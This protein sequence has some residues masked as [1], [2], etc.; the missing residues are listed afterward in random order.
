MQGQ[1]HCCADCLQALEFFSSWPVATPFMEPN[2]SKRNYRTEKNLVEAYMI[3]VLRVVT[4]ERVGVD[5]SF[6]F[7]LFSSGP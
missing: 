4:S 3:L 7:F 1:L 2:R 5:E 6:G